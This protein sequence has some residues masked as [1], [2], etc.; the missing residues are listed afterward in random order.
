MTLDLRFFLLGLAASGAGLM[1]GT[2]MFAL[3]DFTYVMVLAFLNLV[4]FTAALFGLAYRGYPALADTPGAGVHLRLSALGIVLLPLGVA[5]MTAT[6]NPLVVVIGG[7][8]WA[9]SMLT[10]SAT[11]VRA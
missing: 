6:G 1:L 5:V 4:A 8:L 11:F 3:H 9:A 10:F 2:G 7:A